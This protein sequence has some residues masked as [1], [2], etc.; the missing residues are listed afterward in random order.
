MMDRRL[1][2][3]LLFIVLLIS[4]VLIFNHILLFD[5][6]LP[7]IFIYFIVRM[8]VN[9]SVNILLTLAFLFGLIIDIFSDTPGLNAFCCTI[10]AMVR[11]PVFY[12]YSPRDEKMRFISPSVASLGWFTYSKYLLT[13]AVI[14]CLLMFSIEYMSY[15]AVAEVALMTVASA[16]LSYIL[17]LAIDCLM[18]SKSE[19]RL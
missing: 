16:L 1:K 12:A 3:L 2:D 19:K 13:L 6:A 17:M 9:M 10:L 15:A 7:I 18:N 11:R 5:V 8:P 14:Y 4:Q